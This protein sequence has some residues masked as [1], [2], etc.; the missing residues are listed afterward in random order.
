MHVPVDARGAAL[1][2]LADAY[3]EAADLFAQVQVRASQ[4]Q[5]HEIPALRRASAR[6]VA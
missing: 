5:D 2:P 3:D 1:L 6:A 4:A